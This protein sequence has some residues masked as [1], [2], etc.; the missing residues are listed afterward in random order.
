MKEIHSYYLNIGS[1]IEPEKNLLK[2]IHLLAEHGDV[3]AF[4]NAWE[5]NSIGA[6]GPNFLNA[7][8]L[9]STP[10]DT[11]ELKEKIIIF[12][13]K[14]LGRLRSK[15]KNAPRTIDIDIIMVD[16]NPFNLERWNSPFV[17]L[18]LADLIPKF[19]HPTEHQILTEVARKMKS[20]TW[21]IK[22]EDILKNSI[23]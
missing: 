1:N 23:N 2:A 17:V 12:I 20:Q 6:I 14:I 9:L 18:P 21:I 19:I 22:R 10:L 11:S 4:S 15:D 5:S 7:C 3:Q 16:N 8:V 13:E